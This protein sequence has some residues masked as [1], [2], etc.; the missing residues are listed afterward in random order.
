MSPLNSVEIEG[1]SVERGHSHGRRLSL[2]LS[3]PWELFIEKQDLLGRVLCAL[4]ISSSPHYFS[5]RLWDPVNAQI[6]VM[7]P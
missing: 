4:S 5:V 1:A 3:A 2:S 6:F 7:Q